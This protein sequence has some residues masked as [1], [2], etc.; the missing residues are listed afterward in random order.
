MS[1]NLKTIVSKQIPEFI[2]ED[3]PT[4]VAFVEAYY[5]YLDQ[6]EGRNLIELRDIDNTVDSYIQFF[7]NELDIFGEKY[8][9][10]DQRLFLRKVKE[11][12]VAKG[13]ESSYKFLLKLLFNKAAEISY[14]WDSVLKA[15]DGKWQQDMSIF[16]HFTSGDANLLP[17]NRVNIT[18]TNIVIKVFVDRVKYIKDNVYEVFIDKNYY[19]DIQIDYTLSYDGIVG[20]II[21]TT[22]SYSVTQPGSGYKIGDLITGTTVSGGET[23]TQLLKVTKV[24]SNGGVVNITT[25]RFGSGYTAGFYLLKSNQAITT[26]STI[27]IEKEST[28]QYTIPTSS[29]VEQYEDYGYVLNP[30]YSVIE[31]DDPSYKGTLLQQ[32]YDE[33]LSGQGANPDYLLIRFDIG[34]VAKYQG[35]WTSND[36]F[37]DDIIYIQDSYRWQKYSYL[38]TIDENL[39]K[40][41]SLVKSYLHPAGTA[42]FGEYRIQ[43]TYNVDAT[44][45]QELAQWRSK[46]TFLTINKDMGMEYVYPSDQGGQI[47]IEPYSSEDYFVPEEFYNPPVV[48]PFFGDGRNNLQ[49]SITI[50]DASPS[51]VE[52]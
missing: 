48:I 42:L 34:A 21:P 3:N 49:S 9:Y 35:H 40:Y 10:I 31:Y 33:S 5:E 8:D 24:D 41:K 25:L 7:K 23:I 52:S 4:F 20:T 27:S 22:V 29:T 50:T 14:P 51:I 17:G 37:L 15:S 39:D 13:V 44:A 26:S 43:N 46:A 45:V 6:Y 16:V 1:I 36:G 30:N 28:P 12:F 19:G 11:L 38:I 47:L 32:F 2:R 18:S